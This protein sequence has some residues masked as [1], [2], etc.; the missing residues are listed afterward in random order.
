VVGASVLLGAYL[1]GAIPFGLLLGRFAGGIDPRSAGSGNIGATN[2]GR[3]A[4]RGLGLVTLVLD[5]AKGAAGPL[6]VSGLEGAGVELAAG[7]GF[8]AIL[9]HVYPVYLGFRGGK[10]VAT[11]AGV[12]AVLAPAA[13][14]V[15]LGA[16]AVAWSTTRVVAL[17]SLA[18][19]LA[20]PVALFVLG[21]EA[22]TKAAGV[23]AA[24]LIF[25][26]HAPNLR[27]LAARRRSPPPDGSA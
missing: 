13:L 7:A 21:A 9:G 23:A 14:A 17:G 20:L 15:A 18:A 2:V 19:A 5:V 22:A 12:F 27:A 8:A 11:A 26:R 24:V 1:L 25:I 4:G 10:G 6:F 3:T 16:F